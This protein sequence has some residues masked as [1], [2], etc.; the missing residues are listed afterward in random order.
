MSEMRDKIVDYLDSVVFADLAEISEK[1]RITQLMARRILNT[2]SVE[3]IIKTEVD[4][5]GNITYEKLSVPI[6]ELT[7]ADGFTA[8]Y[9]EGKS[10]AM[11]DAFEAGRQDVLTKL[12]VLF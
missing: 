11:R 12:K 6:K 10:V 4:Q 2:L 3:G 8:G 5:S 1:T 9:R 7:Y